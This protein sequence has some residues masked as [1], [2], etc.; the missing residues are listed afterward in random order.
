M[1]RRAGG[2]RLGR[3]VLWGALLAVAAIVWVQRELDLDWDVLLGYLGGSALL[4]LG[5]ALFGGV[6][7]AVVRL[8]TRR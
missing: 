7:V 1:S 3:R 6:V 2:S 4:V 8:F 5:V